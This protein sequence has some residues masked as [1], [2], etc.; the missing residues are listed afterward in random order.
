MNTI[1]TTRARSARG[2]WVIGAVAVAVLIAL[3]WLTLRRSN[4][5][6][7]ASGN[8]PADT[9]ASMAGMNELPAGQVRLSAAQLSQFGVTFDMVKLRTLS[10]EV[11][12]VGVVS[13]DETRVAQ[14][15]SLIHI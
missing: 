10:T 8:R 6:P 1:E 3:W 9:G 4:G 7:S 12:A 2:R 14:I 15:L 11:R 13:F 5:G